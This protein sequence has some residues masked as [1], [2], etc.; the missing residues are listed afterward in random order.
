MVGRL[1]GGANVLDACWEYIS[2]CK[3]VSVEHLGTRNELWILQTLSGKNI[4]VFG[5]E[6]IHEIALT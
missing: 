6:A 4:P 5:T 2:G 1:G 3:F